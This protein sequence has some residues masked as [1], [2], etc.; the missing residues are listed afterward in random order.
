MTVIGGTSVPEFALMAPAAT[1]EKP[2][3][4]GAFVVIS[5]AP[6]FV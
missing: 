2:R 5:M 3:R 1:K 4:S 6:V